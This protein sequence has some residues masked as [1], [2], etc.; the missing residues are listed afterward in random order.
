MVLT[1]L[2]ISGAS[3]KDS[4]CSSIRPASIF[5]RSRM[6]LISASRCRPAPSTRSSGSRSCFN[7]SASS[8]SISVTP[9]MALSGVRSSWLMLARNCDLCWLASASWRLLSSIS[10]NSCAFSD[11]Q[12]R[13]RGEG[14]EQLDRVLAEI[15]LAALRRTTSA[16]TT[17]PARSSGT[18]SAPDSRARR[19]NS[20]T[21][22]DGNSRRVGVWRFM[23]LVAADGRGNFG[24][25]VADRRDHLLAHTEG[26]AEL[27]LA[28]AV[29]E[30]V[31]RAGL[32]AGNLCR[33]G[34]DRVE[35]RLQVERRVDRLAHFA[36]RA[37]L[38]D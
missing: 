5:D 24:V 8:R 4:S 17:L 18:S 33:L 20:F 10:L 16:P 35:H 15:R 32:G 19:M 14:L 36:E 22:V 26:G 11:R 37:Q 25:H 12:H 28:A 23:R 1:T 9:M 6:S 27:E 29:V 38:L 30:H 13:L 21:G 7:A 3:A 34:D 31:D 2:A